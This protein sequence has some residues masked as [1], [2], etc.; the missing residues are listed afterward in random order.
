MPLIPTPDR[1]SIAKE[2]ASG[3][4]NPQL[5]TAKLVLDLSEQLP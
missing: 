5:V 3:N 4:V 2:R 1:F